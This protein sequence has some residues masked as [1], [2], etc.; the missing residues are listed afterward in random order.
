M[1]QLKKECI[2]SFY[3]ELAP[4][5][6]KGRIKLVINKQ[7]NQLFVKKQ[8]NIYNLEVFLLLKEHPHKNI[9]KI[10]ECFEFHNSLIVIEEY[11]SG[12]TL[13]AFLTKH[14]P[15]SSDKIIF[16]MLQLCDTIAFLHSLPAP[17]IHRDLTPSNI[18]ISSDN[19][20][21]VIDF[22][23]AR[24][25]QKDQSEDTDLLGTA[26]YAAPEQYG[27]AQS[28]IRTDIY[29]LGI[30]L[31]KMAT[32]EFPNI[33]LAPSPFT[34]IVETC[35]AINADKR[36]ASVEKLKETLL[37][38]KINQPVSPPQKENPKIHPFICCL[39]FLFPGF[40]SKN[41]FKLIG[42]FLW[43]LFLIYYFFSI[44]NA[45]CIKEAVHYIKVLLL[46]WFLTI[47]YGNINYFK[48]YLSILNHKKLSV[49]LLSSILLGILFFTFGAIL[50]TAIEN[51][52]F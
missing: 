10:K 6:S 14:S 22:N 24:H 7:T 27:F 34:S 15:I 18:L 30:I 43:Y 17:V 23:I 16:Y 20:V 3:K 1:E 12:S 25:Y 35:I 29:A 11:I 13:E 21:K 26:G 39:S 36:F 5:D 9:P 48:K 4:L 47:F 51:I 40:R 52:F 46:L 32:G 38:V 44:K 50:G 31:N 33:K 49:K 8:L 19:Q 42:T 45:L 2:L 28:D 37:L 41:H